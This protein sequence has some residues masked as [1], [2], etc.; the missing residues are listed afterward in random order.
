MPIE[1][2]HATQAAD[3]TIRVREFIDSVVI[4]AEADT[5]AIAA[6]GPN[7]EVQAWLHNAARIAGVFGPTAPIE[8]GERGA[9]AALSRGDAS[10]RTGDADALMAVR[11][12]NQV[13]RGPVLAAHI[14]DLADLARVPDVPARNRDAV[15]H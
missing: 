2:D 1:M 8:Y 6:H 15:T 3:L 5:G 10:L 13:R 4:P 14:D 11:P 7:R 9:L 12:A